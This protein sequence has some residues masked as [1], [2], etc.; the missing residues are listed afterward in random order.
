MN[1][2]ILE[3]SDFS[4]LALKKLKS[5]G[6]VSL[7]E[8]DIHQFVFDKEVLFVR[9][10]HQLDQTFL[11]KANKLKFIC[12]PTTGLNHIDLE[13]C[14]NNHIQVISLK[15]E[16]EFL[17]TIRATPEHTLGLLIALMRNYK[18]AFLSKQ[19]NKFDRNPHKGFEIYGSN[20][21]IIGMGRVGSI[22]A[23]YLKAMSANVFYFDPIE[24]DNCIDCKKMNNMIELIDAS[25]AVFLCAAYDENTGSILNS[26]ELEK[27]KGKYFINTARAELTD[28]LK[29]IELAISGHFKGLAIDVIQNEQAEKNNLSMLLDA[30][31]KHNMIVTPH[32]GGA[33]YTSMHR[34]EVF[35]TEKLSEIL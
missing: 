22:L 23:G 24:K 9:L 26:A 30:A 6:N 25:D 3:P 7:F 34:T 19:N 5:I 33:T 11:S 31:E 35:I 10:G 32:I 18:N 12:T 17:N 13:Y 16:T 27:L 2:G 8:K 4:E 15:G 29:L 21:G 20:I 14:K 28:E 1:I